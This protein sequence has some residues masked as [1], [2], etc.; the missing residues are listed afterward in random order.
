[1]I[2]ISGITIKELVQYAD[3]CMGKIPIE[4]RSGFPGE[5]RGITNEVRCFHTIESAII[6]ASTEDKRI[7]IDIYDSSHVEVMAA[8][9]W[10]NNGHIY[11]IDWNR[12]RVLYNKSPDGIYNFE[13]FKKIRM[14]PEV[15]T[16]IL[17]IP[18][19]L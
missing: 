7:I 11:L 1:M 14:L 12:D 4:E 8:S 17:K 16:G 5:M 9:I 3:Y 6:E 15:P 18:A 19:R 10:L 13:E 2:D